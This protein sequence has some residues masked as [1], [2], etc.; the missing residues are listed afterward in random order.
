M[1]LYESIKDIAK[2][3]QQAG[4]IELYKQLLDLGSQALDM[5][6]EIR[7]LKE[8]NFELKKLKDIEEKIIRHSQPYITFKDDEHQFKYCAICWGDKEKV[9]Q[10]REL[11]ADTFYCKLCG[12]RFSITKSMI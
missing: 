3:V 4:N 7:K 8:E 6:D 12:N 10:L 11:D 1:G 5:Q 9:I 2:V